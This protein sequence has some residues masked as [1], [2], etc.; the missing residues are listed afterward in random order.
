V[1]HFRLDAGD[2]RRRWEPDGQSW[3]AG[4]SRVIPYLHRQLHVDVLRTSQRTAF[5]TREAKRGLPQSVD[6]CA[7]VELSNREF[8][9]RIAEARSWDLEFAILEIAA[10][11]EAPLVS[12]TCGQ[13]GTAPIYL[14]L[15]N[16]TLRGDW[17]VT[18]LY[19]H[20]HSDALNPGFVAAYLLELDHPYSKDT[21]FPEIKHLTERAEARWAAPYDA[22]SIAYPLA[23]EHALPSRLNPNAD[24]AA[25]FRAILSASMRRW[26]AP[27]DPAIAVELSGG[28]DSTLVA[29]TA[30]SLTSRPVRSYGMIMPGAPGAW[31]QNRRNEVIATFGLTDRTAPCID[32][33]P[34]MAASLRVREQ[35]TV[36]WGEFYD[37]AVGHMLSL[38]RQDG[39]DAIF[40]GLGGDEL[41]SLERDERGAPPATQTAW[42]APF[43]TRMTLDA[44]EQLSLL[45]T[46]APQALRHTSTLESNAAVSRLYL[47]HGMWPVNP[48][49]TPEL[50][51]FC[52]RLPFEYRSERAFQRHVL[53]TFGLGPAVAYPLQSELEDFTGVMHFALT[54]GGAAVIVPLLAES[55]LANDGFVDRDMLLRSYAELR[56]GDPACQDALLAVIVLELTIRAMNARRTATTKV[57]RS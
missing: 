18:Q 31:Q 21:I 42:R 29:A 52:R 8:E 4:S 17:D 51:E 45:A 48:L 30:A 28:L 24:V 19:A 50:V 3:I 36:P 13:W 39:I 57:P 44:L 22:L 33:A 41:C 40:T 26:I 11:D 37:E 35:T 38:A 43:V 23:Q 56:A 54:D 2:L 7:A 32:N 15:V 5:I 47:A 16:G 9:R 6:P 34:F 12:L 14:L 46:P 10:H 1:F 49:T 25:A 20:L 55:H 27:D 53:T